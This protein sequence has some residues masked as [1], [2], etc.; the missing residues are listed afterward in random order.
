MNGEALR[1]VCRNKDLYIRHTTFGYAQPA[2]RGFRRFGS[3]CAQQLAILDKVVRRVDER[4]LLRVEAL[5]PAGGRAEVQHAV[6]PGVRH[7]DQVAGLLHAAEGGVVLGLRLLGDRAQRH[8]KHDATLRSH[9]SGL[10]PQ[11]STNEHFFSDCEKFYLGVDA[12]SRLGFAAVNLKLPPGS[13]SAI[14]DGEAVAEKDLPKPTMHVFYSDR[15]VEQQKGAA[16]DLEVSA[17]PPLHVAARD[18][19]ENALGSLIRHGANVEAKDKHP[20]T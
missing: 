7:I 4:V 16:M 8:R 5:G 12:S 19:K 3:Q 10:Q 15:V 1:T 18:G 20:S 14:Y 13:L 6:P 11:G 9:R 17:T 2:T